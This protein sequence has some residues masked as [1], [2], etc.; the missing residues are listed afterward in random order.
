LE[1]AN[2][3]DLD[4]DRYGV[5]WWAEYVPTRRRILIGDQLYLA[6][7]AIETNLSEAKLHLLEAEDWFERFA[8]NSQVEVYSQHGRTIPQLRRLKSAADHL[9]RELATLQSI[10]FFRAVASALDCL[11]TTV[12][13]VL[14]LPAFILKGDLR[15]ARKCLSRVKGDSEGARAQIDFGARLEDRIGRCGP[16]GW[17]DWVLDYR[18][19]FVHRGR[20][21]QPWLVRLVGTAI[22]VNAQKRKHAA[23]LV[24]VLSRWPGR[25]EVDAMRESN[26]GHV[27]TEEAQFTIRGI[28]ESVSGFVDATCTDLLGVW[29]ARKTKPELLIQPVEQWPNVAVPTSGGFKGYGPGRVPFDAKMMFS[30]ATFIRR[31]QAAALEGDAKARWDK[32]D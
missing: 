28:F 6:A 12:I 26:L 17:L 19:L 7:A 10:G 25:G 23:E 20:H 15:G 13:G 4:Q 31:L 18:N 21:L 29:S 14:A 5:G 1:Q 30:A 16:G 11:G 27:L 3:N 9:P 22:W 8:R 32:F 2:L 24:L